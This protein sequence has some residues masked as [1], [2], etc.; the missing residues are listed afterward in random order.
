M[1]RIDRGSNSIEKIERATFSQLAFSE[2]HHLQEWIA[3]A[4]ECLGEELLIV[5][6][7]FDGFSETRERLDLLAIDKS[8]NL[9]V[10]ENKLDDTGRDVVWQAL[11]YASYCSTLKSA[12]IADIFAQFLQGTRGDAEAAILEFLGEESFDEVVLNKGNAQRVLL[13]AANFRKEV[14]AT[15]LWLLGHGI[16]VRCFKVT[17]FRMGAEVLLNFEQII[18]PPEAADYMIGISEKEAEASVTERTEKRRHSL[19]RAFW[20]QCFEAFRGSPVRLFDNITP[21][22]DHW[23]SAGSGVSGCPYQLIFSKREARVELDFARSSKAENKRLFDRFA[24]QREQIESDLGEPLVWRRL[25]DRKS[26]RIELQTEFDGFDPENWPTMVA[27][28]IE[29]MQK[30]ERVLGSRLKTA[31]KGLGSATADI[32]EQPTS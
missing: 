18:P 7:E 21:H 31:A 15:A 1:F 8:G 5:Q 24:S 27:W 4:P 9:V 30:L 19:R 16:D 32:V 17:P 28:M 25:D 6:K 22:D 26:S 23:S 29:N 20:S 13:I 10:I 11:K 12:Q 3:A 14:T 2:R